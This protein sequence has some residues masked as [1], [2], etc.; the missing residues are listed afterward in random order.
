VPVEWSNSDNV[1]WTQEIRGNGWS[2]PLLVGGRLYLTTATGKPDDGDVSLRALSI[3]AADGHILWDK[4]VIRPGAE[5]CKMMHEKNSLAS[6]TPL[7]EGDRL[8]VHFGHM[9]TAALDLNG[10]LLWKQTGVTYPPMHGNGGSLVR[11]DDLLVF[12]CDGEQDPFVV[13]LDAETGAERWRTA[14][15]VEVERTFS[16]CTPLVIE[17]DGQQQIISP[18]SGMAAAYDPHSG[19]ELW[20]VKYGE[21]FSVVPR[22]IFADGVLY[23]CSGFMRANLL[24]VDPQGAAGDVTDSNVLWSY[25]RSVPNTSSI[26]VVG[27][28]VY[29]VSDHGVAT[30]LDSKSGDVQWTERLG[31]DFSASPVCADGRVYFTNE[32][33]TTYVVRAARDYELLAT[34]ELDERTLASPAVDDGAIYLRT[35]SHLWR[36]GQ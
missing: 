4:E 9:G 11:V 14:R 29:F 10:N 25:N 26:L 27:G 31:G 20:R 35:A 23:L 19:H 16:F 28:E 21:G 30:C 36:I 1:A 8:Y 15:D 2:S 33:G 32:D 22:P 5:A 3:D 7:V 34:N 13:A 6:A 12:N 18:G 17:V 24:A